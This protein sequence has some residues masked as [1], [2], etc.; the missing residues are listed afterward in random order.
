[1]KHLFYIALGFLLFGCAPSQNQN[2]SQKPIVFVSIPP[3]LEIAKS[4]AGEHIT[5]RT[6]VNENQSPH[7]YAPTARQ[8]AELGQTK[9]L[10]CI[11]MPFEKQLLKKIVPLYPELT[12]VET[13]QGITPR[14]QHHHDTGECT[15]Q[16]DPHIWLQAHNAEIIAQNINQAFQQLDPEHASDY[17][18]NY[19]NLAQQL[20]QLDARIHAQLAPYKGSRFYVFHPSFGYFAD[21]Y[22]LEQIPIEL[23]GKS[24]SSRQIAH[25]IDQAK[26][27]GIKVIFVQKQFPTESARA[28][29]QAIDGHVAP[30]NPLSANT[31][32][33]LQLITDS[34]TQTF[35]K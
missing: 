16:T 7:N 18:Q 6:L 29:A 21:A 35:K 17:Q 31:L 26:A 13:Q 1:M 14:T 12:I 4:I 33:N 20:Q 19:K 24:P 28:I 25:L 27:D 32:E 8:L 11:G 9:A 22:G 5:I 15:H 2:Q 3:Q 30:L 34:I 10:L 23:D